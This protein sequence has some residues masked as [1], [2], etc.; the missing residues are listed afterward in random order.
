MENTLS[1]PTGKRRTNTHT[2]MKTEQDIINEAVLERL[3]LDHELR[4]IASKEKEITLLR[5][6]VEDMKN[7]LEPEGR[8]MPKW[9][10]ILYKKVDA[11]YTSQTPSSHNY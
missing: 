4:R 10:G 5:K 9:Y 11:L 2:N 1:G 7:T 8:M 6:E 3:L